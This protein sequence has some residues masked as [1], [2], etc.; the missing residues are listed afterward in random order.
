MK[1][2]DECN[3]E[4]CN[5]VIV[6]I[7]EP[8]TREDWED[9]KWQVAHR[10]VRVIKDNEGDW[11]VEFLTRCEMMAPDGK[12]TIY[13]KRP[14]MCRNHEPE[15]CTINGEGSY[16]EVI[17]NSIEDVE[18]YLAE[19]PNAISKEDEEEVDVH[20]CPECGCEF[21]DD[22]EEDEDDDEGNESEDE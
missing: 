11:C 9:I 21:A 19:H 17:L 3:Q 13:E 2:C 7:D 6:E 8:T 12:C 18:K 14:T 4:C 16:Y 20:V 10:N 1:T 15:T 22:D 5:D